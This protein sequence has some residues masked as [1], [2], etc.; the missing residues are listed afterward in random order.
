MVN[1]S[2]PARRR[3]TPAAIPPKPA[4]TIA[5]RGVPS[6]PNSSWLVGD[7]SA[8]VDHELEQVAVRIPHV[9]AR[10]GCATAADPVDRPLLDLHARLGEPRLQ[11]T[12]R[13]VPHEAQVTARRRGRG[14]SQRE[15]LAS[16]H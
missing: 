2:M 12:G 10:P 13:A 11:G 5:T 6:G 16:P 9:H 3:Y 4:P 15:A 8:R 14:C 7:T 1:V